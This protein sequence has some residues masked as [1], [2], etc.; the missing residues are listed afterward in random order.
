MRNRTTQDIKDGVTLEQRHENER[1]FFSTSPWNELRKDRVGVSALKAFLGQLLFDHIRREFPGLVK[2]IEKM[3]ST[4]EGELDKLGPPRQT[5][6]EQRQHLTH[7]ATM[8]QRGVL[9]SL[10]GNYDANLEPKSPLKLR[11][12]IRACN[13]DFADC[14]SRRGHTRV[15]RTVLGAEDANYRRL[16]SEDCNIYDW[17]R[18]VYRDSRGS[19]LPGTVN[20][21]VLENLFRQQTVKWEELAGNYL[22][23][24]QDAVVAFNNDIQSI[25]I[26]D[27]FMRDRLQA[28]LDSHL[29]VATSQ[30][31][32]QLTNVLGDERN[33]ILQTINHYF[34]DNL[35]AAREE[36]V[37]ARFKTMGLVDG[38]TQRI[39][40]KALT[41]AAHLSNEEQ[42]VN[43]VHDILKAYYK[44][45]LK[46]FMDNVVVAV[47]ERCLLGS[48]GPMS[49]FTPQYVGSL[50]DEDLESIAAESYS[51]SRARTDLRGKI[52][53][54]KEALRI[55]KEM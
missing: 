53:R 43:D 35:T 11:M 17:I 29:S 34:A 9:D 51:T 10:S 50:A 23:Q 40:L 22:D 48:T 21:A 41:K 5:T 55:V 52:G 49:T 1:R 30:A 27:R 7:V 8:Y 6:Y 36:R 25:L 28:R 33:G 16:G 37:L 32:S 4:L 24:V 12:H 31:K 44:V 45:A 15:F 19:E 39:D 18:T 54:F 26:T 42:A 46:R 38:A 47:V 2:E 3:C 13:D 20:P 14:L